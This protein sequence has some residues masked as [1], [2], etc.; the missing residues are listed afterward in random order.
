M[1]EGKGGLP[2]EQE[3]LVRFHADQ[4]AT[5]CDV[6]RWTSRPLHKVSSRTAIEAK[7]PLVDVEDGGSVDE[8]QA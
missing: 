6:P 3:S 2:G 7:M 1:G 8:S 4:P 5:I